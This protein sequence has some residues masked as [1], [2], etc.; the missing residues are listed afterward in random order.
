MDS[1]FSFGKFKLFNFEIISSISLHF[2]SAHD[3]I[4]KM[5]DNLTA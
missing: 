1:K 2:K 4:K 5:S 3:K